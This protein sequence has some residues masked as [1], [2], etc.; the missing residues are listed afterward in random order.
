MGIYKKFTEDG[1][2]DPEWSNKY[3]TKK[4]IKKSNPLGH[5]LF[6]NYIS[7][8]ISKPSDEFFKSNFY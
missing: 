3:L 1:S 6:N 4:E 8:V 7:K 5:K 2:L